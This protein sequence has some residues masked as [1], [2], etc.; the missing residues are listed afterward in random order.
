MSTWEIP[1]ETTEWIGPVS[2][3]PTNSGLQLA[4]VPVD[5]RPIE[6]DWQD[7]V[8]L[9]GGLGLLLTTP[10]VGVYAYWA[11][12]TDSPETVVI[13]AFATIKVT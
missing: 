12:F 4:I 9:D 1:R 10:E 7:P 2:V 13:A 8:P 6:A 3:S 11:K 5:T